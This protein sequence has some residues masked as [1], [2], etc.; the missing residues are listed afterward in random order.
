MRS[1]CVAHVA[2][3]LA[4]A[5]ALLSLVAVPAIASTA[6]EE[7]Q[8]AALVKAINA[9]QRSCSSL[10]ADDFE[11]I[12]E[13]AMGLNFATVAQHDAMNQHMRQMMGPVG[14]AS[15]HQAM[16]RAYARCPGGRAFR[17]MMMYGGGGMFGGGMSRGGGMSPG[18]GIVMMIFGLLVIALVILGIVWLGRSLRAGPSGSHGH[19]T[20]LELLDRR[21]AEGTISVDDYHE[22]RRILGAGR[23]SG[24]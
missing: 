23:A 21:F 24:G 8:G 12:G 9:G 5:A 20:P 1:R 3:S 10:S 7:Q 14:E 15:A 19:T 17:G 22:R 11:R 4:A 2:A 18:W 16:G 6:S 13:Y